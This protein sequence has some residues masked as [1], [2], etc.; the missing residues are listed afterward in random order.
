MDNKYSDDGVSLDRKRI[1][2][3][4][5]NGSEGMKK[6]N[7][8]STIS[9]NNLLYMLPSDL[10]AVSMRRKERQFF[11]KNTYKHS[12]GSMKLT[13]RT[14]DT[15]CNWQ[16]SYLVFSLRIKA[17]KPE[18]TYSFGKGSCANLFRS[19]TWQDKSSKII[20]DLQDYNVFKTFHDYHNKNS[21]SFY[22]GKQKLM[23]YN[24]STADQTYTANNTKHWFTIQMNDLLPAFDNKMLGVAN[25]VN[26]SRLTIKL[27]NPETALQL[28]SA[29]SDGAGLEY[30][31]DDC[32]I[33]TDSYTLTDPILEKLTQIQATKGDQIYFESYAHSQTN[34]DALSNMLDINITANKAMSCFSVVRSQTKVGKIK[35]DNFAA[36]EF[37]VKDSIYRVGNLY[38]PAQRIEYDDP[39]RL[40]VEHYQDALYRDGQ[41]EKVDPDTLLTPD[42]F[43]SSHG[44]IGANFRSNPDV[45]LA[46]LDVGTRSNIKLTVNFHT[47]GGTDARRVDTWV[48]YVRVIQCWPSK[49]SIST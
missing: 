6:K 15:Y 16:N 47:D 5:I 29:D 25:L 14:G 1:E 42:N 45:A 21:G 11:D 39:T 10:S 44:T 23:G 40:P 17:T 26:G 4:T 30:F 9:V 32:S 43:K 48:R 22:H 8:M 38:F 3:L 37:K 36:E 18:E 19:I 46:G 27:E 28:T 2:R 31:V 7:V 20:D 35:E 24:T 12:D 13:F 33:M 34:V 49:I 41:L